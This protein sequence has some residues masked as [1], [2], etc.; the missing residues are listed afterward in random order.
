MEMSEKNKPEIS[1]KLKI[2]DYVLAGISGLEFV[3][4][5]FKKVSGNS[6]REWEW[7]LLPL[8]LAIGLLR[9]KKIERIICSILLFGSILLPFILMGIVGNY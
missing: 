9:H 1:M 8:L 5:L 2:F 6:T 4:Q 3:W 7:V